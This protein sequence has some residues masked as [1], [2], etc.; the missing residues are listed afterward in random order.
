M[1]AIE[2]KMM[3]QAHLEKQSSQDKKIYGSSHWGIILYNIIYT[4]DF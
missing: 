2:E 1:K 3:I 4:F